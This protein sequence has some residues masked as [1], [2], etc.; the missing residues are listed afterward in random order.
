MIKNLELESKTLWVRR[1]VLEMIVRAGKGHIGGSLSCVELLVAL[2][3]GKILRYA[4][5]N[6]KWPDRDRFILS[7]GQAC[8]TLYAIFADIG[9]IPQEELFTFCQEGSRLEGHPSSLIPGIE[10]STG[11]LGNGLGIGAGIALS[12]KLDRSD[13]MAVVMLG[14]GE[15]YEG[16]VWEAAMFASH[17]NL[18]NLVAIADRN[19]QCV[20]DFTEDCNKLE[21]FPDKWR[22][23]GWEVREIDGHSFPSI[24]LAFSDFRTRRGKPLVII[25]NTYKG[26]GISFMEGKLGWHHR[27]PRN[28]E[29]DIARRELSDA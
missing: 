9:L 2:Y 22:A 3:Q 5:L 20:L 11:S 28:E 1:Q 19:Q 17:H 13:S 10:V 14:D 16:S 8:Q 24:F 21:P 23:F 7:K 25:A 26:R 4:P 12:N 15:C 29:V 27:I 18:S 6:P